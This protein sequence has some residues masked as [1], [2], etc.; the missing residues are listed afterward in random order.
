MDSGVFRES[1]YEGEENAEKKIEK[2]KKSVEEELWHF[3]N[4]GFYSAEDGLKALRKMEKAWKYH[5]VKGIGVVEGR[6]RKGGGRGRRGR[7]GN[8]EDLERFHHMKA[9]LRGRRCNKEGNAKE[10]E[11]HRG[12]KRIGER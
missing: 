8:G 3:F 5:K 12:Y 4:H 7:P 10:G 6:K 2:E 11:I 9:A 1:F